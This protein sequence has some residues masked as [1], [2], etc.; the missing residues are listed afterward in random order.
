[1][2]EGKYRTLVEALAA[3]PDPRKRRGRRYPGVRRLPLGRAVLTQVAVSHKG[4]E[5]T[6]APRL[7]RQLDLRGKVVTMDALLAQRR[8]ARQIHAQGGHYLMAIKAD[9]P[10]LLDAL[11]LLFAEPPDGVSAA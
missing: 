11:R 10:E 8:L 6:A 2:D 1:M 3:V 7:L 9:Q 5:I 4:N